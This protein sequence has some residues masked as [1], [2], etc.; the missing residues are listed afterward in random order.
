MNRHPRAGTRR[1]LLLLMITAAALLVPAAASLAATVTKEGDTYVFTDASAEAQDLAVSQTDSTVTITDNAGNDVTD[2]A[3][4][5]TQDGDSS[6]DCDVT[7]ITRLVFNLGGNTD[8]LIVDNTVTVP[9]TIDGGDGDD[10]GDNT[11]IT[12]SAAT[13]DIIHGGG[14]ADCILGDGPGFI[15]EGGGNDELFGDAGQDF[16]GAGRGNDQ[17]SGGDDADFLAGG[18]GTDTVNGDGGDDNGVTGGP[19]ADTVNGGE[20]DDFVSGF[21]CQG[22]PPNQTDGADTVSGGNGGDLVTGGGGDD[23]VNGDAGDDSVTGGSGADIVNGGDGDDSL[24][25][26]GCPSSFEDCPDPA[27]DGN[28]QLNGGAGSDFFG[29]DGGADTINGGDGIGDFMSYD[30]GTTESPTPASVSL[31]GAANDGV[32]GEGDNVVGVE[33]VQFFGGGGGTFSGD[34]AVNQFFGSAG[35]D[36]IDPGANNDFLFGNAGDDTFNTRDGFLDRIH[37]GAGNDTVNADSLDVTDTDCEVVNR[38]DVGNANEDR[39]PTVAWTAPASGAT[40]STRTA[41]VLQVTATDDRGIS[42]VIFM[43]DERVVCTD[44]TAPYTCDYKPQGD[45]VGRNTLVALAID[46]SQQSASAVR[47][48]R[49]GRF[50]PTLTASTTPRRD[51]SAPYRFTTSGRLRL[52]T[53]VT[54]AQGCSGLV[55]VQFKAGTKTISSRRVSVSRSCTYRSRVTFRIPSR[56]RPSRLNVVVRYLGNEVLGTDN[57]PRQTVRVRS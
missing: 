53:G 52:P 4:G 16:I 30:T 34:G 51:T 5:C 15:T 37:C 47:N 36:T 7:G 21:G 25:G 6:V 29:Q 31:D 42:Q 55:S 3:D 50:T 12:G 57:A 33:D 23:T 35:N 40:L 26:F 28:D 54:N 27:T 9:Q 39:P 45:D 56:L 19:G 8:F 22:C 49:V 17:V 44:T 11:G 2:S 24:S 32:G 20:G 41:N 43:D 1:L 48:V 14:G 46:T 38:Q 10:C 13:N 18:P